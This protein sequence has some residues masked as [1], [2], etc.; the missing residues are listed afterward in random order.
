MAQARGKAP[1]RTQKQKRSAAPR[2]GA[3]SKGSSSASSGSD[4]VRQAIESGEPRLTGHRADD[5]VSG[6]TGD[7]ARTKRAR[8]KT[9][10]DS[11]EQAWESGRPEAMP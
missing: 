2:R 4:D 9:S 5:H 8:N 1:K 11:P 10:K 6:Q 3:G 7:A